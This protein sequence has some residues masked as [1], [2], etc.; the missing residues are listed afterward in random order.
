MSGSL[1]GR[2][3]RSLRSVRARITVIATALVA[4]T[5]VLAAVALLE[6]VRED[7]L[8][9]AEETID[10]NLAAQAE[11]LGLDGGEL[12]TFD[13]TDELGTV[14]EVW[15]EID[16]DDVGI[17]IFQADPDDPETEAFGELY[18]NGEIVATLVLDVESGEVLEVFDPFF[19]EVLED[20]E[21]EEQIGSL[22]F[23][24]FEVEGAGQFL[25]GAAPLSEIENS[26]DAVEEALVVI[27]PA[28]TLLFGL[29]TWLLVG[30]ALQPV[31]SI[32]RQVSAIS[33]NNLDQRVPVPTTG[34]EVAELAAVMNGMLDRLERGGERQRQFSA[35]ASHEL[36]SPLSSVR[37][38]AEM[39][40]RSPN[41]DRVATLADDIVAESDRMDVLI[42]DLLELSRLD[43][44]RRAIVMEELDL[45]TLVREELREE[46]VT[47]SVQ[48][49]GPPMVPMTGAPSQLRRLVR[50][51]VDN[52]VSHASGAVAVAVAGPVDGAGSVVLTVDDDGPGVPPEDRDRIFERFARLDDARDRRGGGT[53]LGLSLVK[54]IVDRHGGRISVGDSPL[55]GA[56]FQVTLG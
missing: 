7:L 27:V 37:A 48:V 42:G 26:V 55:G 10:R 15:A 21:I 19:Q 24:V 18:V 39:L 30:R 56:R 47:G 53:G 45:V 6:L 51:L 5:L 22:L 3:V 29:S 17:G 44:D 31:K 34:D 41:P 33:S 20:P 46:T 50:N 4:L 32:T 8:A 28:L 52:A 23:E 38:A 49:S 54:A 13:D 16:G 2:I 43:E 14:S 35:D 9:T 40:G 25:V 12:V 36:R 11:L 1:V